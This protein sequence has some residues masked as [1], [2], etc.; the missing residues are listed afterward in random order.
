[1]CR[2]QTEYLLAVPG[3]LGFAD[4]ADVAKIGQRRRHLS[5]DL[6]Q[7]RVVE[8]HVGGHALL[9]GGGSSAAAAATAL[10]GLTDLARGARG[11][12]RRS[13][14]CRLLVSTSS[15]KAVSAS[16]P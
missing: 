8:D 1:M 9:L 15:L 3:E 16:V 7:G 12:S 11:G 14:T 4:T 2:E 13:R 5:G 6:A 10:A